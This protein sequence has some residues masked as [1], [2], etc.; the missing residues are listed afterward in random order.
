MFGI[1]KPNSL[2]STNKNIDI[3]KLIKSLLLL[4]FL[5][6]LG[7]NIGLCKDYSDEELI[8]IQNK[9]R[10]D[11]FDK[12]LPDVMRKH[13]IDMWIQVMRAGN[14]DP[15]APDL[16]SHSGVF[17]FYDKGEGRIERAVFDYSEN[18]VAECGAYDYVSKPKTRIP[19]HTNDGAEFP[20]DASTDL[21][22]R[23][24]GVGEFIA[25][26]NPKTI[27]INY[28]ED[29]GSPLP[30]EV[31]QLR[32]DG[33]SLTDYKLLLKEIDTKYHERIISA[34]YLI[35]D[36]LIQP[37]DIEIEYFKLIREEIA[38]ELKEGFES[39]VPGKTI[40]GDLK[41]GRTLIDK[42]G[43]KKGRNEIIQPG[44]LIC[45]EAG[46]QSD[47][48][49]GGWR[50]GNYAEVSFEYGYILAENE[51]K[52]PARYKQ[53]WNDV[54]KVRK[55]LDMN[56]IS[57]RTAGETF[58]VLKTEL[59]KAGYIYVNRQIFETDKDQSKSQV[60]LDLHAAGKGI[61]APRIGPLGPDWQRNIVLPHNHHFFQEYWVYQPMPE[62]GEGKYLS[63]QLHDG[64]VATEDGVQ[65][66]APF[67]KEIHLIK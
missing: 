34:E 46:M 42:N 17:I 23:F 27:A 45:L 8:Q 57:G 35:T 22:Y 60:P 58:E 24:I 44:D 62:W 26:R 37:V 51:T 32:F 67:P 56:I 7:N 53:A 52:I 38:K 19:L 2:K 1:S 11:K 20:G 18:L 3:M 49:L 6:L 12:V 43:E 48:N 14:Y 64:V 36:Y 47:Y 15:I 65:Y 4:S 39:I 41:N 31:P 40:F 28:L 9:I 30:Y 66:F 21:D 54:L 29:L 13:K 25:K 50:F 61:Y 63:I 33:I 59:D 10:L 5:I 16:G 55:I